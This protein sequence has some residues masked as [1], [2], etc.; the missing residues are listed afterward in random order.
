MGSCLWLAGM[1]TGSHLHLLKAGIH[2][3]LVKVGNPHDS[4]GRNLSRTGSHM[5]LVEMRRLGVIQVGGS[6]ETGSCLCLQSTRN[7]FVIDQITGGKRSFMQAASS[8]TEDYGFVET[9]VKLTA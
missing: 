1:T 5:G 8:V 6:S 4:E 9:S 2:L 3:G 7:S